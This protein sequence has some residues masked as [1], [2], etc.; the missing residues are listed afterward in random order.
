MVNL[1]QTFA[2]QS[3]LAIQNARLFREIEEKSKEIE[4]AN[5]HKSEFLA[6]MSHELRTPL[7]AIIGFSEVLG[8]RLFG[9]LNEKQAEYNEDVLSSAAIFSHSS[10]RSWTFPKSRLGAWS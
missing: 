3:A 5:R 7:N 6:N 8:E 1:L 4:A 2:T 10:T 9:E